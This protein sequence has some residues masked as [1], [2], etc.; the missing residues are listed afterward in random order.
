MIESFGDGVKLE[1]CSDATASDC[2]FSLISVEKSASGWGSEWA[3]AGGQAGVDC[4]NRLETTSATL[5]EDGGI[6]LETRVLI[7]TLPKGSSE[8]SYEAA[9]ALS[10]EEYCEGYQVIVG[11][12]VSAE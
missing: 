10:G 5:L 2:S 3:Q 9:I 6:R 8:C 7:E 12:P 11:S 1:W 4:E